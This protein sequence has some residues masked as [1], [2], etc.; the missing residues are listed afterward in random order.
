M[1]F[2]STRRPLA[3]NKGASSCFVHLALVGL[4]VVLAEVLQ[5]VAAARRRRAWPLGRHQ[6]RQINHALAARTHPTSP[7]SENNI[8]CHP[9]MHAYI[10]ICSVV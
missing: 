6:V 10:V 4:G 1:N 9:C 7:A 2:L 5:R 3:Y 8:I